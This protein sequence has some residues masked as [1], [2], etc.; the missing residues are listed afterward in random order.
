MFCSKPQRGKHSEH[1]H[2][3]HR[4]V[5]CHSSC[6]SDRDC[7][8]CR[9]QDATINQVSHYLSFSFTLLLQNLFT[10]RIMLKKAPYNVYYDVVQ[11]VPKKVVFLLF[12]YLHEELTEFRHNFIPKSIHNHTVA[13][14]PNSPE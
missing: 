4:S 7:D 1:R 9:C 11:C 13:M 3:H 2:H 12:K 6:Y 14:L 10:F 8:N 5:S